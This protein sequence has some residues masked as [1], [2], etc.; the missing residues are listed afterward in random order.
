MGKVKLSEIIGGLEL[1]FDEMTNFLN[2]ETGEVVGIS[3]EEFRAAEENEPLENYPGWQQESIVIAGDILS[4]D[5]YIALP[6][7]FEVDA[8]AMM[9]RFC[10]SVEDERQSGILSDSIRGRGAFRRF[11][12]TVHRY[13]LQDQ[14][15]CFRDQAYKEI[16]IEWCRENRVDFEE[17]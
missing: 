15:Y 3:D 11:K 12:D 16:A 10:W 13:G 7:K 1:Q 9:E 8:Y 14:W 4:T 17:D 6:T 2:K 5:D